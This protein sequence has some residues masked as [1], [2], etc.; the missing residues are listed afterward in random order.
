MKK[1]WFF[2]HDWSNWLFVREAAG[3]G[4]FIRRCKKCSKPQ[5]TQVYTN[6]LNE[7]Q[8]ETVRKFFNEDN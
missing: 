8:E 3:Q 7:F 6:G 4:I 2:N 1:C 5:G